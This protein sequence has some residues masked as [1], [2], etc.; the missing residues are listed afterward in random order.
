MPWTMRLIEEES[1]NRENDL[2]RE[3]KS[4]IDS[5][6]DEMRKERQKKSQLR[7]CHKK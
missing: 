3:S 5:I 2:Q 6:I 1:R 7:R 4:K